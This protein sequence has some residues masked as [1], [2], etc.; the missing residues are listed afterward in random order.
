[1]PLFMVWS[2]SLCHPS[3]Y[4]E[5]LHVITLGHLSWYGVNLFANIREVDE[6]VRHHPWCRVNLRA[7]I[8]V[9]N[10][11]LWYHPWCGVILCAIIHGME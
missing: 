6:S 11:S 1:M 7:I 8:G 3:L 9:Y 4:G 5:N 10:E 2:E